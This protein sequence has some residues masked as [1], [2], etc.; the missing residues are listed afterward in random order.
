[1]RNLLV[2]VVVFIIL[3]GCNE[4]NE[5][6]V[7]L[8]VFVDIVKEVCKDVFGLV[9]YDFDLVEFRWEIVWYI[10]YNLDFGIFEIEL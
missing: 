9:V 6:W 4:D 1:M 8:D 10:V 3:I 2:V 7:V 5:L